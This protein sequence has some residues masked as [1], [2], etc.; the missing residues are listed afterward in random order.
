MTNSIPPRGVLTDQLLDYLDGLAALD[1]LAVGD[2]SVNP[3]A[4]WDGTPGQ[5]TFTPS[6]TVRTGVAEPSS[7]TASTNIAGSRRRLP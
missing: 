7:G 5:G 2:G 4:G 3:A 1:Y 6:L